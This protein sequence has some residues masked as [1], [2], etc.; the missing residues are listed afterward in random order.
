MEN[1]NTNSLDKSNLHQV[2]LD[3]HKQFD[4]GIKLAENIKLEGDFDKVVISG[5]GGSAFPGE[6]V[7]TYLEADNKSFPVFANRTYSL[8]HGI[9]EKTLNIFC[10]YSGNTEET[11]SSL[12]EA[13]EKKLPAVGISSGGELEKVCL[14]NN[15]PFVKLPFVVQPRYALGYFFSVILKIMSNSRLIEENFSFLSSEEKLTE[16]TKKLEQLGKELAEKSK[17]KTLVIYA[18]NQWKILA[19]IWKIKLNENTKIPAFWNYFPELN[20]NEMVGFTLPQ[21]NF[22]VFLLKDSDDH[23]QNQKRM[24]AT[25]KLYK[26]KGIDSETLEIAGENTF[27]KIFSTLILGDWISYYLAILYNQDPTPVEMVEKFKKLIS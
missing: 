3:F 24:E 12:K 4:E 13:I 25:S 20:H 1:K 21:S 19:K 11:L 16:T 7:R 9:N 17:N 22:F 23:K 26:E 6:I 5:M 18:S 10:S 2:I 14:E 15:I 8:P 27:E